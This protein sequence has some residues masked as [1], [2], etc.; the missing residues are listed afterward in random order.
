MKP[1]ACLFRNFLYR[2]QRTES[3]RLDGEN[4]VEFAAEVFQSD[5][6]RE[7]HQLFFLKVALEAIK[8]TIRDP[9]DCI[10]HSFAQLQRQFFAWRKE[11]ALPIISQGGFHFFLRRAVSHP[12]G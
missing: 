6:R 3:L 11:R 12:T 10:G 7:L 9:F 8:K 4:W 5:N 2:R 1:T